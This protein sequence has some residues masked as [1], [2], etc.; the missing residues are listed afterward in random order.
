MRIAEDNGKGKERKEA[1]LYGDIPGKI[2][3]HF[4]SF[5]LKIVNLY[6]FS[7]QNG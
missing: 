4:Q 5:R 7:D 6:P 3:T 1:P 2:N